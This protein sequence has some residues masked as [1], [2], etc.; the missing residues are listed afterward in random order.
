[1]TSA[2]ARPRVACGAEGQAEAGG[3]P[4][5]VVLHHARLDAGAATVRVD[6]KDRAQMAG[7]VEDN[8]APHRLP[9]EAGAGP[10]G[11]DRHAQLG[12]DRD[13]RRDVVGVAREDHSERLDR[14]HAGVPGVDL[15]R[16]GVEADLAAQRVGERGRQLAV[17]RARPGAHHRHPTSDREGTR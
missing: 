2:F 1:M 15:A 6:L 12:G 9:G 10:T 11:Q 4:V 13:R 16:P 7:Q 14:V 3:G 17:A 8:R 5:E